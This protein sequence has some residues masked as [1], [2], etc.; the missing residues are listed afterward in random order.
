MLA[1]TRFEKSAAATIKNV[2]G[3]P[4]S[5]FRDVSGEPGKCIVFSTI[6]SFKGM[7]SPAVVMCGILNIESD[8]SRSLLYVGMSRAR[9]HLIMVVNQKLKAALPELTRK[10]MSGDWQ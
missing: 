6:Q 1:P 2:N 3:V 5:D 4:V 10:R 9:S 7:E 8:E